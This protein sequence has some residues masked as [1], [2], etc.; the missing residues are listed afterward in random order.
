MIV[1]LSTRY[2][3]HDM[4]AGRNDVPRL[5]PQD[6]TTFKLTDLEHE[7]VVPTGPR[8]SASTSKQISGLAGRAF[9]VRW[10]P[11]F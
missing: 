11:T 9:I 10:G 2:M 8:D 6:K 1:A 7:A 5:S 3:E 4:S